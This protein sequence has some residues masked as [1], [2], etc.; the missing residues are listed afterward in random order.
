MRR[1]YR[2]S[3][4]MAAEESRSRS[5]RDART[6]ASRVDASG[7]RDRGECG[8]FHVVDS[9]A[10]QPMEIE[11]IRV[12]V[13]LKLQ[14]GRLPLDSMPRFWG[15][16]ADRQGDVR[17]L[18]HAHHEGAA[19]GGGAPPSHSRWPDVAPPRRKL[20]RGPRG[21]GGLTRTAS[22][23]SRTRQ[24][25]EPSPRCLGA[26]ERIDHLRPRDDP[27]HIEHEHRDVAVYLHVLQRLA[28]GESPARRRD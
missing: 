24:I 7:R 15:G 8:V 3:T 6:S 14:D 25:S 23:G 22:S 2:K 26:E 27:Q 13:R 18:R 4:G 10:R 20:C 5:P 11:A 17:R 19:H 16:P 21:R 12:P 28:I 9:L 1:S